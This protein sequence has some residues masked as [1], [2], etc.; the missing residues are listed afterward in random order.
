MT[1]L[2]L[3]FQR[4]SLIVFKDFDFFKLFLLRIRYL[5]RFLK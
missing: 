1:L 2:E 5:G 4:K 3:S